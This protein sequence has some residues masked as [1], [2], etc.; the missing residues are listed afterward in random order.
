[1]VL[2]CTGHRRFDVL[3][4]A[5]GGVVY[6]DLPSRSRSLMDITQL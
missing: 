3:T 4:R 6:R 1:V 2:M 5:G